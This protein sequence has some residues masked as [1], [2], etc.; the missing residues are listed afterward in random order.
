MYGCGGKTL[1]HI[2]SIKTQIWQ[3]DISPELSYGTLTVMCHK[4]ISQNTCL[5]STFRN[6][7][8]QLPSDGTPDHDDHDQNYDLNHCMRRDSWKVKQQS[9]SL[10][11]FKSYRKHSDKDVASLCRS[12]TLIKL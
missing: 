2:S 1:I 11:V 12:E 4:T 7:N 10:M 6:L 9:K 8:Q 3:D 5:P